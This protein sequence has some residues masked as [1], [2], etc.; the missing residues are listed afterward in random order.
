[1]GSGNFGP[2]VAGPAGPVPTPLLIDAAKHLF[3]IKPLG[4]LYSM[5]S[6]VPVQYQPF[7]RQFSTE[8][9]FDLYQALNATPGAVLER[10]NEPECSNVA[11]SRVYNYLRNF[12][13]NMRQVELRRF[14]RFVTGS[15]VMIADR[16][17]VIFNN[18]SSL[19]RRPISHTCDCSL[20]I[21]RTYATYTE[22]E[23]EFSTNLAAESSI[24]TM[25]SI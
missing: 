24:W 20:E 4:A 10:I 3:K 23:E 15:S 14:L 1:M 8:K 6:G 18:L 17:T 13:G 16:I 12:I 5:Y 19:A 7:W 21:S 25:D 22:F 11:E 9:L 2:A